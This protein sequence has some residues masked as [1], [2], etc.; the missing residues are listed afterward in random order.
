[1]RVRRLQEKTCLLSD[2]RLQAQCPRP[3]AAQRGAVGW[4]LGIE[5]YA[6]ETLDWMGTSTDACKNVTHRH[7]VALCVVVFAVDH[8][9][10]VAAS[11]A[12]LM[13]GI[14]RTGRMLPE[15]DTVRSRA[16]ASGDSCSSETQRHGIGVYIDR[17]LRHFASHLP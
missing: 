13:M 5:V 1:M 16:T 8:R 15:E 9:A 12:M 11:W 14:T 17:C 2:R 3:S 6:A 10:T 4:T 7:D